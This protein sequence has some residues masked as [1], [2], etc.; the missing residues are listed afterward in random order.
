MVG[1]AIVKPHHLIYPVILFLS[2]VPALMRDGVWFWFGVV[3]WSMGTV[4]FGWVVIGS[5]W[6]QKRRYY[7][8]LDDLLNTAKQ[9][10]GDKLRGL[11]LMGE[12]TKIQTD[13]DTSTY[14]Y[15]LPAKPLQIKILADGVLQGAPFSRREWADRRGVFSQGEFVKL[16]EYCRTKGLIVQQGNGYK[17][18]DEFLLKL[19]EIVSPPLPHRE[20]QA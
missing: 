7:D 17:P 6:E 13:K 11:G 14:Y 5:M 8:T 9:I 4:S 12:V 2:G 20:G 10:D 1:G 16:Q 19:E 3:M 15:E 18:S